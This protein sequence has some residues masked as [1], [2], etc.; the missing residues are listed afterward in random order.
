MLTPALGA[1]RAELFPTKVR[2]TA[3]GWITNV[4]IVGSITGFVAGAFL[5]D[6]IGLSATI[7]ILGVGVVGAVLL[8]LRLPETKGM[9]IVRTRPVGNPAP[10]PQN[11]SS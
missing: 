1:M 4:A 10:A 11:P 7:A 3:A 2:A 6:E 9:D 8:T 5:I